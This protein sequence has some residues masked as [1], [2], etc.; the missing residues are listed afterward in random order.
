M[1]LTQ[2]LGKEL[3]HSLPVMVTFAGFKSDTLTLAKEG[4]DLS[5]RQSAEYDF[6]LTLAIRH[7]RA[8]LHGISAPLSFRRE[9]AFRSFSDMHLYAEFLAQACFRIVC[10][11]PEIQFR[12]M[13]VNGPVTW[14]GDFSAIDPFPQERHEASIKDFKFFKVSNPTLKDIIV[15]PEQVPE[16]LDLV[17]KA[18][19]PT[20]EAI[21]ARMR[22]RENTEW[23]RSNMHGV[24]PAHHVQA[25]I[26]TLAS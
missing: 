2:K 10:V 17:M 12:I 8:N 26:I 9:E 6:E 21:K 4:W 22:S 13:P 18:Q 14:A 25:Q 19:K 7:E 24:K 1:T 23:V 15:S 16:L 3:L 20:Q 5:M 11:A